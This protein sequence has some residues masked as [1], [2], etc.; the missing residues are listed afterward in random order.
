MRA[1]SASWTSSRTAHATRFPSY[2]EGIT[3][4][5]TST[6]PPKPT[7]S[8]RVSRRS[9]FRSRCSGPTWTTRCRSSCR[10]RCPTFVTGSS[11]CTAAFSTPCS[12]VDT[13]PTAVS[14]SA[15]ASS[16]MS[17]ATTTRTVTARSTTP[18]FAC[19]SHGRCATRS[20]K[21][22]ATSDRRATTPL[23]PCATPRRGWRHS[24][25]RWCATSTRTPSTSRPTTTDARRSR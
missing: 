8:T 25:W 1:T 18:S 11:P 24:P 9:T 22:R 17:W 13:G 14:P 16:A 10:A 23:R 12:T 2:C 4:L 3:C 7:T 6:P 19:R 21:A 20:C 15:R 5:T